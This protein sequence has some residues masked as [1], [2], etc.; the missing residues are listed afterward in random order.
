MLWASFAVTI[1]EN[2][3]HGVAH[4]EPYDPDRHQLSHEVKAIT[5]HELRVEQVDGEWLAEVIV[6]I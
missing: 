5:Y 2:G 1:D 3:L 6:D 4:G